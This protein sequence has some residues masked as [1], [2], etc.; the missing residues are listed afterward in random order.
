MDLELEKA[1]ENEEKKKEIR[2]KYADV[3]FAVIAAQ[4]IANTA[5]SIMRGFAEL[6]PIGG[7]ISAALLGATG[8]IQLGIA[9]AQR[10]KVKGFASGGYTGDGGMYEPAGIVHK[11]EYV[12]SQQQ[13]RNPHVKG[14]VAALERNRVSLSPEA[15]SLFSAG[16]YTS[17][18]DFRSPTSDFR[19]PTSPSA[20]S[21]LDTST[22]NRL[23]SALEKFEKKKLVVYTEL[24]KKDLETLAT[25]DKKREL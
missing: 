10:Q 14:L 6:G 11:G 8:L 16:G 25:I 9:N 13:L 20:P 23:I 7:A 1:G 19:P 3:N 4:I 17:P 21:G 24:I 15:V 18:S 2:K 22:A 12:V 5:M